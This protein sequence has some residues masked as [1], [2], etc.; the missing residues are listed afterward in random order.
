MGT[1]FD[2]NKCW[3][4]NN[5]PIEDDD[6]EITK[7]YLEESG[8]LPSCKYKGEHDHPSDIVQSELPT[9]DTSKIFGK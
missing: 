8:L 4:K 5:T 2:F 6:D 3:I 7:E 1:T 9:L